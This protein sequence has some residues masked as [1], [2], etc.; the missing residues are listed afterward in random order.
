[1]FRSFAPLARL[2]QRVIVLRLFVWQVIVVGAFLAANHRLAFI[3]AKRHGVLVRTTLQGMYHLS[4][5]IAFHKIRRRATFVLAR[6]TKSA[7]SRFILRTLLAITSPACLYLCSFRFDTTRMTRLLASFTSN[8]SPQR[9]LL[10][11]QHIFFSA[12]SF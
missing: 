11:P 6:A 7:R 2:S 10:Q 5:V 1:M 12:L 4:A 3:L 9:S 8:R